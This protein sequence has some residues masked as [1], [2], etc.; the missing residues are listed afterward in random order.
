M[1]ELLLIVLSGLVSIPVL[2]LFIQ[3]VM[4]LITPRSIIDG[5]HKPC[6]KIAVLIPAHNEELVIG[7]TI[8]ALKSQ[9][10]DCDRLLVVADNCSDNTIGVATEYDAEVLERKNLDERG[11]GYALDF[12]IKHLR[13]FG[14]TPEIVVVID[15]D[16]IVE[17]GCLNKLVAKC[18]LT[19][20]PVQALYL[21]HSN[22]DSP[23][24][25]IA[26]FAWIIKNWVRPLGY[27]NL[28]F[29]CQ[30][31]GTG[32][33]FP[34]ALLIEMNLAN[35]SIVEDMKLGIDLA[36]KGYSPIFCPEAR[37]VSV[38]P[39]E[40][41]SIKSQRTRWEHGHLGVIAS[42]SAGLIG[43]AL[44]K[45]DLRL[46]AMTL[47]LLVPPLALLAVILFLV[48]AITG[49]ASLFANITSLYFLIMIIACCLF[50]VSVLLAWWKFA[51]HVLSIKDLASIPIYIFSKIP[52]YIRF[53]TQR[54]KDWVRTDRD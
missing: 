32:M 48:L 44:K 42:E 12:G 9:L 52:M 35:S 31:M 43:D 50:G 37:V 41:K 7:E 29:P 33:A 16:C 45:F 47:D 19:G 25:K 6:T 5:A 13:K 18:V 39:V 3:V 27:L 40:E 11:K 28:G 22:A 26:E 49:L 21:M 38:F 17:E 10:E 8:T 2:V 36:R 51:R 46:L 4:A 23:V 20:R 14:D 54:Q 15:A 53:W 34:F 30:L 1:I 24:Q